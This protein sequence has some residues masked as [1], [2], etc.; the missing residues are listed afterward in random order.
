MNSSNRTI[1]IRSAGHAEELSS[2]SLVNNTSSPVSNSKAAIRL[3]IV[4]VSQIYTIFGS[5]TISIQ[6]KY[7]LPALR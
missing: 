4:V 2:L 1:L 3:F 7:Y 6:I 5:E